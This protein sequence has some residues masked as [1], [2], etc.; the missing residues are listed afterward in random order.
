MKSLYSTLNNSHLPVNELMVK[1]YRR[2]AIQSNEGDGLSS[3]GGPP[4]HLDH[5]LGRRASELEI[6]RQRSQQKQVYRKA[7]PQRRQSGGRSIAG[8]ANLHH[9]GQQYTKGIK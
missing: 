8:K 2:S 5:K 7:V 4:Y 6:Y 1:K 9:Q 3:Q